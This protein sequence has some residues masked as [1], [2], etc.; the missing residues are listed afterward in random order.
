[1]RKVLPAGFEPAFEG[2]LGV[3]TDASK[4]LNP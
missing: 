2:F 1:V 4:A 3:P